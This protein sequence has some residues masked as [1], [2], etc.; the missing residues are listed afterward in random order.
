MK[1]EPETTDLYRWGASIAFGLPVEEVTLAQRWSFKQR[2]FLIIYDRTTTRE[3]IQERIRTA[4][5]QMRAQI[6]ASR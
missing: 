3:N 4:A 5:K 1:T 6:E 2:A